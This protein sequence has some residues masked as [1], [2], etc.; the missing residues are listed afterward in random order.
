MSLL[1]SVND[2]RGLHSLNDEQLSELCGELRSNILD[3]TLENGG[4]LASSLGA[5]ELTVA[6]LR[7]FD[8]DSDKIIFDVGHQSYA[9]KILTERR[10][11]FATLRQKDGIAG[12]PRMSESKY[13]FFTT[14]H[15]ST[16]ISAA[17][18]YAKARD[19][20]GENHEVVAVIGDGA[21][22]NG[23][24]FEALNSIA[25]LKTKV[26]IVLNDNKMSINPRVGGMAS[27]LAKL[28]VNPTYKKLK[29]YVKGQ[30]ATMKNGKNIKSSISRVKMKLKS[31][32]LPTNVFEEL[33]IS[34]WGPFDGH[35]ITEM[36]EIFRFARIH[37][38]SVIIHVMTAKGK[39]C[40]QTEKHPA[41]FHGIGPKTDINAADTPS[42]SIGRSWSAAMANVLCGAAREDP[43]I[44]VC[45][46]AMKE[47]TKLEAFEKEFPS[48]FYDTGIAE[49]HTLIY[50]A[51]L[52]AAGMKPAVCIYSTFLQ[53]AAD[54][55]VHDICLSKLPVL[56]GIDRAG[57]V[58]EDGETH[59]GILDTAWLRAIPN[60]TSAAPRDAVDL[61]FFVREWRKRA[62]PLAVRYPRGKAAESLCRVND[63][64]APWGKL[65]VLSNGSEI[66]L[67]GV[68]STVDLMLKSAENIEKVSGIRPTVV[69]LRFI[70]PL[71]YEGLD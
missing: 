14:G 3:V 31:L 12:F 4:H 64:P 59:H 44:T 50:A 16:S 60:M 6:L 27:H 26:I 61:E 40:P 56:L 18:G 2:F 38:E 52:A 19:L 46:A 41:F 20:R 11:R 54:Q 48:R 35:N 8:P 10:E 33:K 32:L 24:A 28:A 71:D 43:S 70:K 42:S 63:T 53:R 1:E 30:C 29:D 17:S 21:L 37:D 55:I 5:V 34:Y 36:E 67:I 25:A 57:L 15:S 7:V 62:L 47:G 23:V 13:D 68:G 69:D 9:Y 49:E 45:T 58:G 51:G 65:E 22:L 39:G 66:C